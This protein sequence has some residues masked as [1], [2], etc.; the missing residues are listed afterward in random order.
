[1][2]K[3]SLGTE[4]QVG[5]QHCWT[6]KEAVDNIK[7]QYNKVIIFALEKTKMAKNYVNVKYKLP[8]VLIV[9]NEKSGIKKETLILA[10]ETIQIP[11]LGQHRS[12]NVATACGIAVF[13]IVHQIIT[14][15]D[16]F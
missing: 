11:M 16:R 13:E 15:P 3:T 1:M 2:V 5:W 10:D 4:K 7:K 6:T 9:G 12:L 14:S 8:L